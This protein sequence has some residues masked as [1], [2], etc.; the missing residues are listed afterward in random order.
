MTIH[1]TLT[2][3][4]IK[5]VIQQILKLL[6]LPVSVP[7]PSANVKMLALSYTSRPLLELVAVLSSGETSSANVTIVS[8][9]T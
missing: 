1:L 3:L 2:I 4:R 6:Y 8:F 7:V 9:K 5:L